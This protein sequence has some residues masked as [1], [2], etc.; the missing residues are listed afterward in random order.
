MNHLWIKKAHSVWGHS[1]Q[2]KMCLYKTFKQTDTW[3]TLILKYTYID[4][5]L[6]PVQTPFVA[7]Y[8]KELKRLFSEMFSGSAN[9]I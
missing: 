9:L 1:D 7:R 8:Q 3:I 5:I 6:L 4:I 2:I